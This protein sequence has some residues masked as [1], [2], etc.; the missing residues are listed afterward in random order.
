M[1]EAEDAEALLNEGFVAGDERALAE[2][3]RRWSPVVYASPCDRSATA[4][5]PTCAQSAPSSRHGPRA[6][7]RLIEGAPSTW[8]VAV[9]ASRTCTNR[10]PESEHFK[11]RWSG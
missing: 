8:L 7:L 1:N 3:Y 6:R 9:A 5:T 2:V 10:A 11:R 4:A